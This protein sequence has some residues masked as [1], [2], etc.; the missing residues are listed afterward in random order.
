[1]ELEITLKLMESAMP[2]A[3]KARAIGFNHV[4]LEVGDIDE[5][6]ASTGDCSISNLEARAEHRPSSI[7]AISSSHCK[8]A[9]PNRPT[10]SPFWPGGQ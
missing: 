9:A 6:L 5:A 10:R 8:R 4:A 7:W 1:M 3:K 2:E